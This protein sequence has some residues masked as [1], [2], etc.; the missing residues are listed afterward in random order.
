ML[1]IYCLNEQNLYVDL[2]CNIGNVKDESP[3]DPSSDGIEGLG[4]SGYVFFPLEPC[5]LA[6]LSYKDL[7]AAS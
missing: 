6:L 4:I 2:D 1:L 5:Y 7:W 3:C